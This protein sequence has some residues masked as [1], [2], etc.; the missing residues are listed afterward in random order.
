MVMLTAQLEPIIVLLRVYRFNEWGQALWQLQR[1]FISTT[2]GHDWRYL[3]HMSGEDAE[4][5]HLSEIKNHVF[6]KVMSV[7]VSEPIIICSSVGIASVHQ[8]VSCFLYHIQYE[9]VPPCKEHWDTCDEAGPKSRPASETAFQEQL[10]SLKVLAFDGRQ[11][12]SRGFVRLHAWPQ[13]SS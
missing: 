4:T 13:H 10:P 9:I 7:I 5:I 1:K 3:A 6:G 12:K 8:L 11:I 2:Q